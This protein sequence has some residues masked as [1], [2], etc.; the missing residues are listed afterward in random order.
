MSENGLKRMEIARLISSPIES[1][2]PDL[3]R[4]HKFHNQVADSSHPESLVKK[5]TKPEYF[6]S[7]KPTSPLSEV[8]VDSS[9][10][11]RKHE[12]DHINNS[13]DMDSSDDD[14]DVDRDSSTHM[15]P[16]FS[17]DNSELNVP[18]S[19][20]LRRRF[21]D[22]PADFFESSKRLRKHSPTRRPLSS[23]PT[24][25]NQKVNNSYPNQQSFNCQIKAFPLIS[26]MIRT[27]GSH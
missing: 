27:Y 22:Y 6:S 8:S 4:V 2:T 13:M 10:S 25:Q 21:P 11:N 20:G 3:T 24:H 16:H 26:I 7:P 9:L 18:N 15:S 14:Y 12:Q 5:E 19:F 17:P 23:S 1:C